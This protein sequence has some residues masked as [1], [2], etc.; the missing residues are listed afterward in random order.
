MSEKKNK[1]VINYQMEFDRRPTKNE[2]EGRIWSLLYKGF[3]VRTV[4]ENN[5]YTKELKQ[6]NG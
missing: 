6:K 2:V 1:Y 4:E 5:F 3:I